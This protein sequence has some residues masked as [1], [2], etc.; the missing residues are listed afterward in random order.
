MKWT[1]GDESGDIEDRRDEGG[2][3]GFQFGGIH[4][5]IGGAIVLAILSF[6][7]RTNLF[8]LLGNGGVSTTAV[9]QPNPAQDAAEKPLVEFVSFVLDD[10][11]KTWTEILPQQ[12]GT[13]YRHAKLVLFRDATDSGCG[14]AQ[15][16]TGPFYCPEDEHVYIDLSFFDELNRRFGAPG[17]FAQAYV[18][19]HELG[20]HI[21][22]LTGIEGKVRQ[23]QEQNSREV[24]P[25]SVKLELQ[26]DCFAGIWAHSTQQRGLLEK[27]DVESAL[28]AA[29]AVGDDRLQKMST[30]HV[31][32][33]SF[34]HGTSEQRM[35]WFN[36]GLSNGTITACNTFQQPN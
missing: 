20:H 33:E 18:L 5:G 30:G 14:N 12:T 25:L 16:A 24:N 29:S 7:F 2:G 4:I 3:G 13:Q 22:K 31:S 11:Q 35:Q 15:S 32:P 34:T 10:V 28:G 1:P 9:S 23:L 17:Q 27:G 8:T 6:V 21:Q 36:A 26:A 19:A